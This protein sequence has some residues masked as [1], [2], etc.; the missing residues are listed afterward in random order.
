MLKCCPNCKLSKDHT[1]YYKNKNRKYG[2]EGICKLCSSEKGKFWRKANPEKARQLSKKWERNN[3]EKKYKNEQKWNQS[4][5]GKLWLRNWRKSNNNKLN[6]R[7]RNRQARKNMRLPIWLTEEDKL[8]MKLMY[9]FAHEL[10]KETGIKYD[11]DH[12]IPLH[13]KN[14]SGLHCP[15]NLQ[16]LKYI[17]NI[18]KGNR[19]VS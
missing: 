6:F 11:V 14:I 16:I 5:I 13:G 15:Q 19:Y 4:Y 1:E 9:E 10:S 2:I 17:D 18:K 12:I 8:A 3:K 7:N